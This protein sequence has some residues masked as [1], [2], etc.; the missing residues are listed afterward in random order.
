MVFTLW[1]QPRSCGPAFVRAAPC[2]QPQAGRQ[3]SHPASDLLPP[4]IRVGARMRPQSSRQIVY[5]YVS[6]MQHMVTLRWCCRG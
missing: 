3:S 6:A 1:I 2:P 4:A 5:E